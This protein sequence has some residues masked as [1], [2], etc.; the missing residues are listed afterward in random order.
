MRATCVGARSGRRAI[1]T[2][3]WVVSRMSR[4]R[5][6]SAF[7]VMGY[8][9]LLE[10]SVVDESQCHRAPR[11]RTAECIGEPQRKAAGERF[12][13]RGPIRRALLVSRPRRLVGDARLAEELAAALEG[14]H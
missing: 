3:P 9:C 1:A 6:S 8:P 5:A 10:F 12:R 7:S 4:L 14:E 13:Q 2:V 11:K